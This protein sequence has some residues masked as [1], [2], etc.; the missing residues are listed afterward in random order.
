[1]KRVLLTAVTAAAS[2]LMFVGAAISAGSGGVTGP[3]FYV[4]GTLYRTVGTPTDLSTTGAPDS[5]FDFRSCRTARLLRRSSQ[6]SG[7]GRA[8]ARRCSPGRPG[9]RSRRCT[10]E[11]RRTG[12]SCGDFDSAAEVAAAITAGVAT[13]IGVVKSFVCPVIHSPRVAPPPP[14][15]TLRPSGPCRQASCGWACSGVSCDAV[16]AEGFG[17]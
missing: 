6:T 16:A 5:S 1:M 11:R 17:S 3:S 7:R 15:R 10:A 8:N 12:R 2:F 9:P 14:G 13:D 4:D